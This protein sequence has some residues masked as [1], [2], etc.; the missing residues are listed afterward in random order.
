MKRVFTLAQVMKEIALGKRMVKREG[1]EEGKTHYANNLISLSPSFFSLYF[2]T[3]TLKV[4][5]LDFS[6]FS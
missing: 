6:S 2:C 4:Y 3:Y 1:E 5:L